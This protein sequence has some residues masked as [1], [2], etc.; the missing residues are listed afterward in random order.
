MKLAVFSDS[1]GDTKYLETA[2]SHA[3]YRGRAEVLIHLGDDY[4]VLNLP[5]GPVPSE[6]AQS[7]GNGV[8][9]LA[10]R[11]GIPVIHMLNIK[12]LAEMSG[13]PYDAP[14]LKM[15]P[16]RA[17]PLF[18][19]AGLLLFFALLLRHRRWKLEPADDKT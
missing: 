11:D 17:S 1:H 7:A 2:G 9:G 4:D 10:M 15:A 13:I 19:G 5:T 18:S 3:V 16:S 8:I 12:H 6:Y 14:P